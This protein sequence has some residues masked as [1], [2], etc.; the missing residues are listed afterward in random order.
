MLR[1]ENMK[2]WEEKTHLLLDK[3][4][5]WDLSS[6]NIFDVIKICSVWIYILFYEIV[7]LSLI[8]IKFFSCFISSLCIDTLDAKY[9]LPC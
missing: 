7:A 6:F 8:F 9:T 2:G 4:K 5:T 3:I 1:Q